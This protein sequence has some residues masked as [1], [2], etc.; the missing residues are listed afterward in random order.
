MAAHAAVWFTAA[1]HLL[2]PSGLLLALWLGQRG[3]QAWRELRSVPDLAPPLDEEQ[4]WNGL[5]FLS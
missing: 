3:W 4:R 5:D 1:M 2:L